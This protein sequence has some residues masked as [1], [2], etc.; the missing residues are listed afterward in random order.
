LHHP[1]AGVNVNVRDV[2]ERLQCLMRAGQI[3]AATSRDTGA[4]LDS[5][6]AIAGPEI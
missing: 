3:V 5:L 6:V 2:K 4:T 1:L